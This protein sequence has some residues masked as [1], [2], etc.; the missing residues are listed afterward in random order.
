MFGLV[1]PVPLGSTV[2]GQAL[3]D[4]LMRHLRFG[5]HEMPD[6]PHALGGVEHVSDAV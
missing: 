3:D 5:G 6:V 2:L 4:L 1:E